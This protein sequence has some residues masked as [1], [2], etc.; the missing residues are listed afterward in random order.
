LFATSQAVSLVQAR[1]A[2]SHPRYPCGNAVPG[3]QETIF[4]ILFRSSVAGVVPRPLGRRFVPN[5]TSVRVEKRFSSSPAGWSRKFHLVQPVCCS[6]SVDVS[7]AC[8][9]RNRTPNK[10]LQVVLPRPRLCQITPARAMPVTGTR[11]V[12]GI[13]RITVPPPAPPGRRRC[14]RH[15]KGGRQMRTPGAQPRS[16][17]HCRLLRVS[18]SLPI[19]PV[20]GP[21]RRTRFEIAAYLR[22]VPV[23]RETPAKRCASLS[24]ARLHYALVRIQ[25]TSTIF[26]LIVGPTKKGG[27]CNNFRYVVFE[28]NA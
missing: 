21:S 20:P 17:S 12:R 26:E 10:L 3:P 16:Y 14:A 11:R 22:P 4:W 25:I 8:H 19:R 1:Y 28:R 9:A 24:D 23:R 7:C 18:R 6:V 5:R 27:F 13:F 2:R 15:D